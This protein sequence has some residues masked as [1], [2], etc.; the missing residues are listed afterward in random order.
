M[1]MLRRTHDAIV[2][3]YIITLNDMEDEILTLKDTNAELI[4]FAWKLLNFGPV[5]KKAK[6][7]LEEEL[8]T[9][10]SGEEDE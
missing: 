2:D 1:I 3:E 10:L 7:Q 4:K 9:I 8:R 5:S 6:P